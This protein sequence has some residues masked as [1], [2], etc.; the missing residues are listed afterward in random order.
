MIR[1]SDLLVLIIS[2]S[3]T[4]SLFLYVSLPPPSGVV[5]RS[6]KSQSIPAA[7][8]RLQLEHCL[9]GDQVPTPELIQGY[10]KKVSLWPLIKPSSSSLHQQYIF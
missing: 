4:L 8:Y 1:M 6:D 9:P 5:C 10:V 2:L 3:F 7:S